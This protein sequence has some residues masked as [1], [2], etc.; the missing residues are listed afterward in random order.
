M[1]AEGIAWRLIAAG[2]L[3]ACGCARYPAVVRPKAA[4]RVVPV[5]GVTATLDVLD[6]GQ[7]GGQALRLSFAKAGEERRFIALEGKPQGDPAT[8]KSVSVMYRLSLAQG[9]RP[10]LALL[11]L[12]KDGGAWLKVGG[13]PLA[14]DGAAEARLPLDGL[15]RAEFAED[16]D[17]EPRRDQ[18]ERVWLGLVLDGPAEGTLELGRVAFAGEA[19]RPTA[20]LP[21][22]CG[23]PAAWSVGKDAAAECRLAPAKD[24]PAGQPSMRIE[25]AFPGG[26]H[27]YVTP[28][29]RLQDVELEG[30]RGVRF[31][32]KAKLPAG[33]AGL[34]VS[35][36]ERGDHSQYY[37]EQAP[38]ASAEWA[39]ADIAFGRLKLG[40][41][42]K[43]ENDRLDLNEVA[44]LTIGVHGAASEPKASGW[45]VVS[46]IE[47][48]P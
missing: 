13:A 34:L 4:W 8:A 27:M 26:R 1:R 9:S 20:P 25:F 39:V 23:D 5:A 22:A 33:I 38:E 29:L 21:I 42:S 15:R 18:L 10:K 45:I 24:G 37:A 40:P 44:S 30:Y 35:V 16:S 32:Y 31:V 14:T 3:A 7:G 6:A 28:A 36:S 2:L 48:V 46:E 11:V 43:D 17:P 41:W 47:L 19:Y 12:E